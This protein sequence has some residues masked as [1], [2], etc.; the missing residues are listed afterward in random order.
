MPGHLFI[1]LLDELSFELWIDIDLTVLSY[2]SSGTIYRMGERIF[3]LGVCRFSR[4]VLASARANHLVRIDR[5]EYIDAFLTL[6]L[7][8]VRASSQRLRQ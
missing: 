4:V 3:H 1:E 8:A 5:S 7:L 2:G 6:A